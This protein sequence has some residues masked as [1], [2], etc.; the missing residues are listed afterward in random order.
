M[1]DNILDLHWDH[2]V[3]NAPNTF[4][5]LWNDQVFADVTLATVDDQQI[6]AH[7]VILSSCSEFFRNIFLK[8][9][10]QNPLLYIKGITYKELAL[11]MK[12]IYLGQCEVRQSELEDLLSTANDLK[13][14]GLMENINLNDIENGT[15]KT[16]APQV[17]DSNYTNLDDA[18]WEM[19]PQE[20]D[21]E[22][23]LPYNQQEGGRFVCIECNYG[24]RTDLGLLRHKRSKHDNE[25]V[26][27]SYNQCDYKATQQSNLTKHRQS[28]HE[29]VRYNCDQCDST[30]T[31]QY[32]VT[33]HKQSKHE[34]VRYNCDQCDSTFTQQYKVT[35]HKQSKHEGV[36]YGCDQCNYIATQHSNLTTHKQSKHEG[37]RF[38]CNQ[39][40][41]KA[42]LKGNLT[43][44]KQFK[45]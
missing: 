7:K 40:D 33:I 31:Q 6:R 11:V 30:F 37:V 5:K 45:H 20:N 3:T 17:S 12:F 21:R 27:Y 38:G 34:G 16:Q 18:S 43:S 28:K 19:S 44:H 23:I 35:I 14:E 15:H 9:P 24:F 41:Y 4:R 22:V 29:G 8:N 13:V 10:H 26:R 25:E 36:R 1:T 2:F 32:K 42:T 39:C